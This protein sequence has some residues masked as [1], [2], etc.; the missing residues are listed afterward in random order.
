[1]A[2]VSLMSDPKNYL[3]IDPKCFSLYRVYYDVISGI[4]I[5]QAALAASMESFEPNSSGIVLC[6]WVL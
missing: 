6:S 1:M 5:S 3:Q 2:W 4:G